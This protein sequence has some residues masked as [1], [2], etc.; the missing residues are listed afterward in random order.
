MNQLSFNITKFFAR[1]IAVYIA[2]LKNILYHLLAIPNFV[3]KI[4]FNNIYKN[5][6]KSS[7]CASSIVNTSTLFILFASNSF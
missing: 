7:A 1:L 3:F 4:T 6:I 5:F 2:V